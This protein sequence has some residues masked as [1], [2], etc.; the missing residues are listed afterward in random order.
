MNEM[1]PKSETAKKLRLR[2]N[3][4]GYRWPEIGDTVTRWRQLQR[5]AWEVAVWCD[6]FHGFSVSLLCFEECFD[7][8]CCFVFF[9]AWWKSNRRIVFFLAGFNRWCC[10]A[11]WIRESFVSSQ[12]KGKKIN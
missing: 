3:L 11:N 1:D 7:S 2:E 10:L 12:I 8:F 6:C 5:G 9:T 4:W